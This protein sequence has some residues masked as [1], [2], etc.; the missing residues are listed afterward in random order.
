MGRNRYVLCER[1]KAVHPVAD[2]PPL[3]LANVIGLGSG[4]IAKKRVGSMGEK[5]PFSELANRPVLHTIP[6][7]PEPRAPLR[8]PS[9]ETEVSRCS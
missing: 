9:P 7:T 4:R 6:G 2:R 5:T 1:R 8:H 3:F